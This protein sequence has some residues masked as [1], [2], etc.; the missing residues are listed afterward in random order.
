MKKTIE[1]K[2]GD[3]ESFTKKITSQDIFDFAE[4]SGDKNPIH[5]DE[6]YA[7]NSKFKAR[8]AHGFH[9][10]SFISAAIGQKLPGNG[11]IY[12]SQS[13]KFLAPV[14]INDEITAKVEVLDFPKP[15]RITLKTT[16]INQD[17]KIVIE[18]EA[19]VIPPEDMITA[20][21]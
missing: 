13:L 20:K 15:N 16:C 7:K 4:V 6:E 9:V 12:L 1:I 5:L 21:I 11:T 18:G 3:C 17:G 2:L 8:I 14:F 19:L 10:G